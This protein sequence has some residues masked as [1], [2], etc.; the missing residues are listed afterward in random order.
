MQGKGK[1]SKGRGNNLEVTYG[2]LSVALGGALSHIKL[3]AR[4]P[5]DQCR[6]SAAITGSLVP[7]SPEADGI[8]PASGRIGSVACMVNQASLGAAGGSRGGRS[9]EGEGLVRS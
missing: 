9:E 4:K 2:S 1:G 7:G 3:A 5:R 8:F 6:T